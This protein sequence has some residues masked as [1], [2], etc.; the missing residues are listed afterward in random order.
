MDGWLQGVPKF[1]VTYLLGAKANRIFQQLEYQ[2]K[3]ELSIFSNTLRS[4]T[5]FGV[6]GEISV[7]ELFCCDRGF[8]FT[9]VS[10][11]C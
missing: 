10:L 9:C 3:R 4:L 7:L 8:V 2:H 1:N 11:L 5:S 6:R